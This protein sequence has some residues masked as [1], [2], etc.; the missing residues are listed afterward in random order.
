MPQCLVIEFCRPAGQC[1]LHHLRSHAPDRDRGG[2]RDPEGMTS[3][4]I[5]T[6]DPPR[7]GKCASSNRL[8]KQGLVAVAIHE[9]PLL[10]R[11]HQPR[12]P[13]RQFR[14]LRF[15][16][17]ICASFLSS[18]RSR[19]FSARSVTASPGAPPVSGI[20]HHYG[21]RLPRVPARLT[22]A[23][24]IGAEERG[25]E[26]RALPAN[27]GVKPRTDLWLRL[28]IPTPE[29]IVPGPCLRCR[30]HHGL[31]LVRVELKRRCPRRP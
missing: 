30:R 19:A 31:R 24:T 15:S 4:Y 28:T 6:P 12:D 29:A 1:H 22:A 2:C 8:R 27:D 25:T 20:P 21:S 23:W 3:D 10:R 18:I 9:F 16:A 7:P 11:K 26:R 5:C 17:A 13:L 14:V